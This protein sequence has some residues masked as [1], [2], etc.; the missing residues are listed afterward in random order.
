MPS[1]LTGNGP[2]LVLVHTYT[3]WDLQSGEALCTLKGHKKRV[4]HIAITADGK[5]AIS[6]SDDRTC[7]VWDLQ[8]GE[9]LQTLKGHTNWVLTVAI[10]ADGKRAIS[11]SVDKTCIVWD[12]QSGEALQSLSGHNE[13]VGAVAITAD[14]KRAISGSGSTYTVWDLQSGDVLARFI[15][16]SRIYA[17]SLS[18]NG[19]LLGCFSGE[20]IFLN[21]D[22]E[23]LNAGVAITTIRQIWDFEFKRY[24]ELSADCPLCGHRFAAPA[25][26]L[27]TISAITKKANLR[28]DQSPCLELPDEAWENP[29]LLGNCPKCG[30]E[31][32]FNPFIAG[33]D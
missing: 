32:K 20:V 9:A 26:V 28:P 10:T 23:L 1:L 16:N 31:L 12:M 7:I 19:I 24:L 18:P 5:R 3:V 29:G 21:A 11:G 6:G 27:T 17:V 13:T 15:T 14:G 8:S 4:E 30:A 22:K 33:G 2:S 25:S